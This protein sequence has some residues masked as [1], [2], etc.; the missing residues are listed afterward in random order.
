MAG[1]ALTASTETANANAA[2]GSTTAIHAVPRQACSSFRRRKSATRRGAGGL[3]TDSACGVAGTRPATPPTDA[4]YLMLRICLIDCACTLVGSG[5]K[6]TWDRYEVLA[7]YFGLTAHS[8]TDRTFLA[9]E[10][11]CWFVDTM[12]YS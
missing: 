8:S 4:I 3:P 1:H 12:A 2:S 10:E 5:W 6:S 9:V 7:P 11:D